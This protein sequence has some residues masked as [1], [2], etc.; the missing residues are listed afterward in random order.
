MSEASIQR[1]LSAS[2][3]QCLPGVFVV[4]PEPDLNV[5]IFMS[6]TLTGAL[7]DAGADVLYK[8]YP[9]V[10]HG[11]AHAEGEQTAACIDDMVSFISAGSIPQKTPGSG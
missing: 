7:E 1:L 4:Q 10:A 11:F 6:Q 2:E 3:Q 5:P 8:L 9:G